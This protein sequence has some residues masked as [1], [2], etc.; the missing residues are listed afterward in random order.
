MRTTLIRAFREQRVGKAETETIIL[1][2]VATL[3]EKVKEKDGKPF[4]INQPIHISIANVICSISFGC[5][6]SHDDVYISK[7]VSLID[8]FLVNPNVIGPLTFLPFLKYI[9]FD[10]F[11]WSKLRRMSD[12]LRE[13][14]R[15]ILTN[16]R[17]SYNP[18][19]IRDVVDRLIDKQNT[20]NDTSESSFTDDKLIQS[21]FELFMGGTDTTS[22]AMRWFILFVIKNPDVQHRMR[23]EIKENVGEGS[24]VTWQDKQCL[25]FC[26]AVILETLRMGNI[27]PFSIPHTVSQDFILSDYVIPK[28]AILFPS[29][30]SVNFDPEKFEDVRRFNPD[31]FVDENGE[32]RRTNY[33]MPFSTGR[34]ACI[35]ESLAR[36][37]LFLFATNLVNTFELL[38]EQDGLEPSME[39]NL[40]LVHGPKP[41]K[42]RA[43]H[44]NH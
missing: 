10:P 23:K 14:C 36:M 39:Y 18:G 4:D 26:E 19:Q 7:L 44:F 43:V 34:R 35:G 12:E 9:P 15:S 33:L 40:G 13:H 17:E 21:L 31:R 32:L 20:E 8:D 27:A 42:L 3:L 11:Q 1:K 28:D 38:A 2:E 29:I 41:Y 24:L 5:R 25:R 16:H 6:Y 37:E 30:D 22:T